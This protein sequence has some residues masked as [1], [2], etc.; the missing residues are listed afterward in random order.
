MRIEAAQF[1]LIPSYRFGISR[2]MRTEYST[3]FFRVTRDDIVGYGEAFPSSRYERSGAENF[4]FLRRVDWR[5]F[6]HFF[7]TY[8]PI[9]LYQVARN[10]FE[11]IDSLVSGFTASY[12]DYFAKKFR[13]SVRVLIGLDGLT[14][15]PTSFTIGIDDPG[16]IEQKIQE[17]DA[18]PILK[19]KLGTDSDEDIMRTV[20]TITDKPLRI[21]ANEGWEPEEAIE[22][23][24]WLAEQNVE[25]VEQPIPAGR[26]AA[27]RKV[28]Q[29]STLPVFADED[30]RHVDDL[31]LLADCYDGVNIKLDKCGGIVPGLQMMQTASTYQKLIMLGCMVESSAGIAPAAALGGGADYLDLDGNLLLSNDPFD[32]P[33]AA[34]GIFPETETVGLG[35][36][37]KENIHWEIL[38]DS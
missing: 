2:E 32:G 15:P 8:Q 30:C 5:A 11:D 16:V 7:N 26:H 12:F 21:D 14:L 20:R 3:L 10:L 35:V 24:A 34:S 37:E 1:D 25:L 29:Q 27:M 33:R 23:I 13:L 9:P 4:A 19:I 22:K 31:P 18:Y 17:A 36:R 38:Y 28:Y 6:E